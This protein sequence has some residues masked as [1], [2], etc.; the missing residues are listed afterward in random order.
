[1]PRRHEAVSELPAPLTG[2]FERLSGQLPDLL[3]A[4]TR[5]ES[6][7]I[8]GAAVGL[9]LVAVTLFGVLGSNRHVAARGSA[10]VTSRSPHGSPAPIGAPAPS[11]SPTPDTT[12]SPTPD[13]TPTPSPTPSPTRS[14]TPTPAKA[15]ISFLNAPLFAHRGQTVT[16]RAATTPNTQCTAVPGYLTSPGAMTAVSDGAGLV[17]WT[18]RVSNGA[19]SGTWP[20][21]VSCG[22]ATATTQ[23][24]LR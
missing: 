22:S 18:W 19:P 1:M 14:P 5:R 2:W 8:G 24:T 7:V 9:L 13:T 10:P 12:D 6:L 20:I 17:S 15:G 11:D 16:L 3:A 21:A 23:I 4:A